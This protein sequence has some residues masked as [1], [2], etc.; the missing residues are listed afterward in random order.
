MNKLK[1]P[2]A[3]GSG[4]LLGDW[5]CQEPGWWTATINDGIG[6]CRESDRLWHSYASESDTPE[7]SPAFRNML[8]AMLDA[9]TR[10]KSPNSPDEPPR[11]I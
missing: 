11:T 8:M 10:S 6:V 9:E 2:I 3:V 4:V 5:V 1:M 7:E